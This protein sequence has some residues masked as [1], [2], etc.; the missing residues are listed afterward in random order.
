MINDCFYKEIISCQCNNFLSKEII[1]CE[2]KECDLV[3]KF[4]LNRMYGCSLPV[5]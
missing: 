5:K 4:M 3:N 1:Y 2:K